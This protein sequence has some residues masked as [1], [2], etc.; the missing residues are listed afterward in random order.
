MRRVAFLATALAAV[1][2]V[3]V[4]QAVDVDQGIIVKVSPSKKGTKKKPR[5]IKL[6]VETTTKP[7][8]PNAPAFATTRAIIHFDKNLVFGGSKFKSCTKAQVQSN[9]A[10][11]PKGSKV[12]K[13]TATGVALGQTTNLT[14]TAFNGPKGKKIELHV[15]AAFPQIDSVIEATIKNDTGAYGKKLV[16]PIPANLQQPIPNVY[17][18]LTDFT[19]IVKG[20]AKGTPYVGLIGCPKDKKLR[21]AGDFD[22]SDGTSAKAATTVAC[23]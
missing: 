2:A 5:N 10:N 23:S 21:F 9:E 19:T 16:V 12:G 11:C 8:D 14:I 22:Y 17:A 18:T 15:V 3:G 4:A 6:S 13:G 20:T 1:V 7:K